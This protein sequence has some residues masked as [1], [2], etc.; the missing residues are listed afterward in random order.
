MPGFCNVPETVLGAA[1]AGLSQWPL[2]HVLTW[3]IVKTLPGWSHDDMRDC[4]HAQWKQWDEASGLTIE[5]TADASRANILIGTRKID[6]PAGVLAEAQLPWQGIRPDSQLRQWYDENERW[7]FAKNPGGGMIDLGRTSLHEDG[8]SLGIGHEGN[9][10]TDAIMDPSISNL[11]TLQEWDKQ[12]AILRYGRETIAP[13]PNEND[14]LLKAIVE[15]LRLLS[16]EDK[17][18]I[19][20]AI[21]SFR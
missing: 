2:G 9:G 12:Q 16:P 15:C 13:A 10:R 21:R 19:A 7:V 8:H 17:Q 11:Y 1:G 4:F 6:G 18:L 20:E 3:S 5:W 14:D